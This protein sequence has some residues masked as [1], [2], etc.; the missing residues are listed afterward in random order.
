MCLSRGASVF[1][2]ANCKVA[3]QFAVYEQTKRMVIARQVAAGGSAFIAGGAAFMVGALSRLISDTIMYPTRRIKVTKQTV[4]NQVAEGH[5]SKEEGDRIGKM[6]NLGL[7]LYMH[8]KGGF[9]SVYSGLGLEL[10]RGYVCRC[11]VQHS[12]P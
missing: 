9:A 12:I 8:E 11:N 2:I 5:I 1:I 4:K 3:I 7:L 10:S 6:G